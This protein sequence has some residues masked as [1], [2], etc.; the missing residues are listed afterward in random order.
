[1]AEIKSCVNHLTTALGAPLGDEQQQNASASDVMR[2]LKRHLDETC[3]EQGNL[4]SDEQ[5]DALV[6]YIKSLSQD[7]EED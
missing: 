5:L 3:D 6:A 1:M 7:S 2:E 4:L